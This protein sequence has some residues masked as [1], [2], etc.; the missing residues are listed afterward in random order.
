MS[1]IEG[2]IG[3]IALRG[4]S[5]R[6]RGKIWEQNLSPPHWTHPEEAKSVKR[7]AH[8]CALCGGGVEH[9]TMALARA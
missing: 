7:R 8:A 6:N 9:N 4:K 1:K 2:T 5:Y 3:T